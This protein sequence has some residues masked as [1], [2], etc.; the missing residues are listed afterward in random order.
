MKSRKRFWDEIHPELAFFT[1]KDLIDQVSRIEK[2]KILMETEPNQ[3][4]N[5]TVNNDMN[6]RTSYDNN[7]D[8]C[9]DN[10]TPQRSIT[11]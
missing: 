4:R 5:L 7:P 3:H 1:S 11:M 9:I 6:N 2:R 10:S 8:N